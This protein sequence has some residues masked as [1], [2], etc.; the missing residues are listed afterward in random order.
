MT[1]A[2]VERDKAMVLDGAV[3]LQLALTTF[4]VLARR[5]PEFLSLVEASLRSDMKAADS[6]QAEVIAAAVQVVEGF[7]A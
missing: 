5:D 3:A 7:G 4:D 2:R 6:S 1:Q